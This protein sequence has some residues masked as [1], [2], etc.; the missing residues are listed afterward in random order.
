MAALTP[1]TAYQVISPTAVVVTDGGVSL[2]FLPGAVFK[3]KANNASVQYL[4]SVQKIVESR[5]SEFEAGTI[6]VFGPPGPTGPPGSAGVT[7]GVGP[8]GPV[9]LQGDQGPAGPTGLAGPGGLVPHTPTVADNQV[10]FTLPFTPNDPALVLV[11]VNGATYVPTVYF[12]VSGTTLTWLNVF[13][14]RI[15]DTI[16]FFL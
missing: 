11:V 4:L 10:L 8:T 13:P 1:Y 6:Q 12:T 3:A 14:L 7:G 2:S 9:G 15:T 5:T 16:R